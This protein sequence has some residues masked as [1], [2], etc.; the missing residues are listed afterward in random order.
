MHTLRQVEDMVPVED[1]QI[2][3]KYV[4]VCAVSRF[5]DSTS[6]DCT[7]LGLMLTPAPPCNGASNRSRRR[8]QCV[9]GWTAYV[10]IALYHALIGC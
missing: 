1:R 5:Y 7:V 10:I 6:V 9:V 8:L 2:K 4:Y 3:I